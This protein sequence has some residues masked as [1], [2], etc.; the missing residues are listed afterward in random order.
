MP[1]PLPRWEKGTEMVK[2]PFDNLFDIDGDWHWYGVIRESCAKLRQ[3]LIK[4]ASVV[5]DLGNLVQN[6]L[7]QFERSKASENWGGHER[8]VTFTIILNVRIRSRFAFKALKPVF[9]V[10]CQSQAV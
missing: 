7:D 9:A 5:L 3:L 1:D 4:V 10:D 6:I 8:R 2:R